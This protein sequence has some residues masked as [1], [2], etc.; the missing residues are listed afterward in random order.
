MSGRLL[1][2]LVLLPGSLAA[3]LPDR[4]ADYDV[5]R[6]VAI[7]GDRGDY[8]LWRQVGWPD[9]HHTVDGDTQLWNDR[10]IGGHGF[11]YRTSLGDPAV[12]IKGARAVVV[13]ERVR[14]YESGTLTGE[15]ATGQIRVE[16]EKRQGQWRVLNWYG[17]L[18][19]HRPSQP[20]LKRSSQ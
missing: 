8:E 11:Q 15:Y 1:F 18:R 9:G 14:Q 4:Q 2:W 3:K 10:I 20:S 16:L 7:A 17:N 6:A 12:Q 13:L 5:V 19:W